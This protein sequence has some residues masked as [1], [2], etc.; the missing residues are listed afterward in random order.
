MPPEP[1]LTILLDFSDLYDQ[2][3]WCP[4]G[5]LR[6]FLND[7]EGTA[8]YCDPD[9]A[10]ALRERLEALPAEALHWI[11]G[12]DYH[13]ASLFWLEKIEKPF[14]LVLIDNHPDDQAPAFGKDL[15]SCGGWVETARARLPHLKEVVWIRDVASA[16][17]ALETQADAS[18]PHL[19][20]YLSLDLDALS[21][22]DARTNWDQ[23]TLTL[24]QLSVLLQSLAASRE[25]LGV[26]VCGGLTEAQG[27]TG[28]DLAINRRTRA[29]LQELFLSLQAK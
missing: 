13:Y 28:E 14:S 22:D 23:G 3:N 9:A 15:L 19:P 24:P 5:A 4:E 7:L 21:R 26:D 6:V 8:C 12:G 25:W 18:A 17:T 1:F 16:R 27:A 10:K 20:I 11:G 29:E 2:E